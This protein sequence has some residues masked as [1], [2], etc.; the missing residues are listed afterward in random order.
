MKHMLLAATLAIVA[1]AFAVPAH[2]HADPIAACSNGQ[3]QVSNGGE[4]AASGHREAILTF[5]L[6]PGAGPCTLTGYPGV[7]SGTGG[8]LIHAKRTLSGFMGGVRTDTPP[9]IT[10][11]ASQPAHAVVEGVAV[12]ANDM[13]RKCPTYTALHVTPPDTTDTAT[14]PIH[15][16][17]C[18][19]QV[20]PVD[21]QP[22]LASKGNG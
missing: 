14:I 8:P 17:T 2:A 3:V 21:S 5:S 16:D 1:A 19:M 22:E 13:A 18:E 12:D 11:S 6:V 7:D 9:T 10:V 4:Q 20:H 15:M